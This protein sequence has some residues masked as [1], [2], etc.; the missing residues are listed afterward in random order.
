MSQWDYNPLLGIYNGLW[1]ILE[2]NSTFTG[3]VRPGNRVK[4]GSLPEGDP[5]KEKI[6]QGDA[7]E[8]AIVPVAGNVS[9]P[10]TSSTSK[11]IKKYNIM[12]TT[13]SKKLIDLCNVEME[14]L[15]SFSSPESLMA[16][17]L[18]SLITIGN[19]PIKEVIIRLSNASIKDGMNDPKTNDWVSLLQVEVEIWLSTLEMNTN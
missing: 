19:N 13:K 16:T 2:S 8:V 10:N 15:N 11:M 3:I 17:Y 1:Y 18:Q 12:M 5:L 9:I 6:L 4:Y 14:V 7:P